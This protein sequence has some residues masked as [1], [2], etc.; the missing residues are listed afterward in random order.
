MEGA[1]CK[2]TI[3]RSLCGWRAS[4]LREGKGY[5]GDANRAVATGCEQLDQSFLSMIQT[6]TAR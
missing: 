2:A 5:D 6:A 1:D 3:R 4:R